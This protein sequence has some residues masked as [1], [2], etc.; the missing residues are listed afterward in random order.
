MAPTP[1][2]SASSEGEKKS[3]AMATVLSMMPEI[4]VLD[5]PTAGLDPRAR[6]ALIGRLQNLEMTMLTAS[7]DLAMVQEAFPR[8]VVMDEGVIVADG[9]TDRVLKDQAL[10]RS[11]G[12]SRI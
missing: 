6:R 2:V 4:L 1:R 8:V 10:L 3:I 12:L 9:P 11:H 7:H 5:E